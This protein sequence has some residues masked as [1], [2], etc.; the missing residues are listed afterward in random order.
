MHSMP[1]RF[2]HSSLRFF[3]LIALLTLVPALHAQADPYS[4]Y[5]VS[6]GYSWISNSLNG[7]PGY[8]HPL[9]GWDVSLAALDWHH[10]RFK[11]DISG[12]LGSNLGA[13]QHP[14]FILAGAEYY[15]RF[16][17]ETAFADALIGDAGANQNWGADQT[18]GQSASFAT[19]AGGG[20][21]TPVRP[22]LALRVQADFLYANFNSAI[23]APPTPTVYPVVIHNLPNF[24]G[25]VSTGFVWRF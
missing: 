8:R 6:G 23:T 25:R 15:H 24:F 4:L 14:T 16:N 20:L 11:V 22:R 21:D 9:S 17:R 18:G 19:M 3:G 7:A 10:L 2:L 1:L 5:E 12:Y 13:P